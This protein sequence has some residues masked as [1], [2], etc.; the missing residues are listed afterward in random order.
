[1]FELL[2]A[3]SQ[4][5]GLEG[6]YNEIHPHARYTYESVIGG[7]YYNSE[8]TTSFYFGYEQ[9]ITDK[10]NLEIGG[11]TG[12]STGDLLPYARLVYE[13]EKYQIFAAP[14]IETYNGQENVGVVIGLEIPLIRK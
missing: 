5:L 12:Y 1:M 8:S 6:D 2:L 13:E 11:V 9:P 10:I 3:F 4:H 14:A 7:I